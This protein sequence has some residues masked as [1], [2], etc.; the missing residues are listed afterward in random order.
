V[1]KMILAIL[2]CALSASYAAP[3]NAAEE[4]AAALKQFTRSAEFSGVTLFFVHMNNRTV[5]ALFQAPTKYSMRARANMSTMLYVQGTPEKETALTTD[6]V[7]VQ[8]GQT[9]PGTS[10]NIK[11]FSTGTVPKGE[12]I[13][14]ILQFEMKIDPAHSFTI[15]NGDSSVEFKLSDEALKMLE[16]PKPE[17]EIKK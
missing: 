6:F 7:L 17:A 16:P 10:H 9:T 15:K 3:Q 4:N 14:G 2:L 5:E 12:R 11:N 1:K 8:D 13:D